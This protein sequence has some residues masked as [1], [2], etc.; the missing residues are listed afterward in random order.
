MDIADIA[1]S[2]Y[3]EVDVDERLGKV[4]SIFER[5]NPKGIIV[6]E[7]GEY[8]G[9]V[10]QKQL[11]QSHVE[12]K[13]KVGGMAQ[14]APRIERTADVRE[15]ARVL[16]ESGIK[17]APVFE[18]GDLWGV[19]TDDDILEAVLDNLDALTVEQIY[20]EDVIS[21]AQ[22]AQ[23][24]QAI[25]KLR[26]NGIS[27]L[28]VIDED[29]HLSGMVT[30]H[31]IVDVV[32]RDMDKSTRGERAGDIDRILD[33][34]I[35]DIMN[36]PV[37]TTTFSASVEDA[38]RTMLEHDYAGLVVTPSEDDS[39]VAGIITKTD[40]LRALTFTEEEHMDVQITNIN[41]LDT[42]SRQDI[43]IDIEE[44]ADKYREMQVQHA[45]VRFHEHKEKLRGTPL[46]QCQ[47][48]LRTNKGQMAGSG[49]GY[50]AETAFNVALD[51]LQRNVLERK[52]VESDEEYQGQL[53]RK[54]GEL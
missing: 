31:D 29:G 7:D 34:P 35:Y 22:D 52:G 20:T 45:H 50:G 12:D 47:I 10:T 28:P 51:K 9:V 44:V 46:I 19:I 48:R 5:E 32:V 30:R 1:T 13:T 53:L 8:T 25:N 33:L 26:E 39:L 43:R 37:E 40:V 18:A 4:R 21:I 14:N 23:V 2:E 17:V 3:V 15:T 41:L 11:V 24:G 49:E 16:V 27:R 54:L 36:S 42:I 38:V 6:T